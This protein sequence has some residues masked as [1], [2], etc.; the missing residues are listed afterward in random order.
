MSFGNRYGPE[1]DGFIHVHH[2]VPLSE[3]RGGYSIDPARHLVPVC[4]NCHAVLHSIGGTVR[5]VEEVREM[6]RRQQEP[7]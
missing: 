2:L 7:C 1:M 4:P 5:S 6:L 3:T